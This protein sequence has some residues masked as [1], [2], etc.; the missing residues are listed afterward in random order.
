MLAIANLASPH[1]RRHIRDGS[2]NGVMRELVL[3]PGG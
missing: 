1:R 2:S 3:F